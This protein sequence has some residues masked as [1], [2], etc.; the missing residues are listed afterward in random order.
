[1]AFK[2]PIPDAVLTMAVST[3]SRSFREFERLTRAQTVLYGAS[4]ARYA[5]FR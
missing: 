5:A 3:S 1:M 4:S 2:L